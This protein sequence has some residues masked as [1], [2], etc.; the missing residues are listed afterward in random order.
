MGRRSK[1]TSVQRRHI[2]SQKAREKLLN[3]ANYQ[4]HSNQNYN[5]VPFHTGQND[6]HQKNLQTVNALEDVN[7]GE[8]SY[9]AGM[10]V[11]LYS[12]YGEKYGGS[13]KK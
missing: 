11:N 10:N 4:R 7:K 12:H 9:A 8:P 5:A 1:Y 3:I 13:L 2:D 6:H